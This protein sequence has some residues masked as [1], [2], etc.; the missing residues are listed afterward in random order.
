MQIFAFI[1]LER[2]IIYYIF[3]LEITKKIKHY[4]NI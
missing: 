4:E 1:N 2:I 3:A